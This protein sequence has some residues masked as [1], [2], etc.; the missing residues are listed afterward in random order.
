M[1]PGLYIM[2]YQKTRPYLVTRKNKDDKE[3][4]IICIDSI[5]LFGLQ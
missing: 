5:G 4:L 3:F 1:L 2:V